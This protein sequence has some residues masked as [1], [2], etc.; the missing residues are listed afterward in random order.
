MAKTRI[1]PNPRIA[2]DQG[3]K[4][5]LEEGYNAGYRDGGMQTITHARNFAAL[6]IH[7]VAREYTRSEK[8]AWE[9]IKAFCVEQERIYAEEF[10]GDEDKVMVAM[11][12]VDRIYK[13]IDFLQDKETEDGKQ[14]G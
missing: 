10:F 9:L 1:N 7:N 8:K 12:H 14:N 13:K 5:G 6:A 4:K 2:F 3:V 11:A